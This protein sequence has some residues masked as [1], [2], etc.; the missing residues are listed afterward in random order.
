MTHCR[1]AAGYMT[2]PMAAALGI[3]KTAASVVSRHSYCNVQASVS[4]KHVYI[5]TTYKLIANW[6]NLPA[7]AFSGLLWDTYKS[8]I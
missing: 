8:T 3:L 6:I 5:V 7:T 2:A 4:T 1:L